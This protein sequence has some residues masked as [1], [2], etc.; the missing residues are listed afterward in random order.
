MGSQNSP[1]HVVPELVLADLLEL[2]KDEL[3]AAI[4]LDSLRLGPG[5]SA[6]R[7]FILNDFIDD[8]AESIIDPAQL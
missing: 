5:A 1:G 3:G 7:D 8:Q 4:F 6:F 2:G